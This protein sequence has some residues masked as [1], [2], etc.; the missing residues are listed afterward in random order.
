M[1][2]ALRKIVLW[3]IIAALLVGL[4]TL[5]NN[6]ISRERT[7]GSVIPFSQFSDEM[8]SGKVREVV[9]RGKEIRGEFNDG[10]GSFQTH[11][12][13]GVNITERPR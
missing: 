11:A 2:G 3:G 10:R 9:I 12:P 1:T 6:P 8:E 5:F 4:F 7:A 13:N